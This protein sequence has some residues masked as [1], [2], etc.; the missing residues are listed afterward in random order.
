MTRIII[1]TMK[2]GHLPEVLA[3]E[4]ASFSAP[5]SERSFYDELHN[6]SSFSFVAFMGENVAGY[7][8]ARKLWDEGHILNLAVR[9]DMRRQGIGQAL[10]LKV[11]G[12]LR[13]S[14]CRCI[15]LEVRASNHEAKKLYEKLGFL[16][17]GTRKAYYEAPKEDALAMMREC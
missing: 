11:V 1:E 5:W 17:T 14:A 10:A 2:K 15:Y 7:V 8:C 4:R 6:P 9:P 16:V 12:E 3:I 13:K